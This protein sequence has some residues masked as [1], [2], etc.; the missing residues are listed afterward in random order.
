[1]AKDEIGKLTLNLNTEALK[2]VIGEGRI[3]LLTTGFDNLTNDLPLHAVFVAFVDRTA[4]YLSGTEQ[5]SG[6]R[7]VDSFVQLR[8]SAQPVGF[9]GS[10]EVIDP[11]GHR[12]LSLAEARTAQS[13][14]LERAGFYQIHFAN[15]RDAVIGVNPDRRESNLEP[16]SP[17]LLAL[18]SGSSSGIGSP[19]T[20]SADS[21][22]SRYRV[23]SF[24]WYV[25]LLV[26]LLAASE[27][28]LASRYLGTLR[29]DP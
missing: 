28:A 23:Q 1:M 12:P 8:A 20:A 29:E 10:V 21:G 19:Q 26:L 14:R 18:W 11:D 6:S 4:R 22:E 16:M 15:S 7:L 5:L 27:S 25:M 24:W 3:L 9:S 13:L 2:K 17:D